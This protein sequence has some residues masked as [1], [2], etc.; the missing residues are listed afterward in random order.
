MQTTTLLSSL[1]CRSVV[2]AACCCYHCGE[3]KVSQQYYIFF[4]NITFVGISC[5]LEYLH[6]IIFEYPLTIFLLKIGESMNIT[7]KA[8]PLGNNFYV[9]S[10]SMETLINFFTCCNSFWCFWY[11]PGELNT[12]GFQYPFCQYPFSILWQ[13]FLGVSD[14]ALLC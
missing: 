11:Q 10:E 4:F 1:S 9:I 5:V 14:I 13:E 12:C 2:V 3:K 6:R 8:V 7:S